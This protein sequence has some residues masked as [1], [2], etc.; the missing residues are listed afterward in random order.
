MFRIVR[1]QVIL[2]FDAFI[3][4][5]NETLRSTKHH[6][7]QF[8]NK[9]EEV[10]MEGD[11]VGDSLVEVL[12]VVVGLKGM[13]EDGKPLWTNFSEPKS[14]NVGFVEDEELASGRRIDK[15]SES[16]LHAVA[17]DR[18][19]IGREKTECQITSQNGLDALLVVVVVVGGK[20]MTYKT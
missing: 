4:L 13:P 8:R 20:S 15:S 12:H 7:F 19:L 14:Y 10:G 16:G 1:G 9:P 11:P 17:L 6:I 5:T 3:N 2:H 18:N